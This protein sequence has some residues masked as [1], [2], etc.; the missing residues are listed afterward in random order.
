MP[1]GIAGSGRRNKMT[2]DNAWN[3]KSLTLN[4]TEEKLELV[5]PKFI[6][7]DSRETS[8]SGKSSTEGSSF[9]RQVYIGAFSQP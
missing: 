2:S 3:P 6:T 1:D 7:I 9:V 8:K 5:L 4:S